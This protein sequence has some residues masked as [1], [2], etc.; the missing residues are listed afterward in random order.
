MATMLNE[1]GYNVHQQY[2]AMLFHYHYIVPR[3]GAR[4]GY[5]GKPKFESPLGPDGCPIEY[6]FKW[7]TATSDPDVR[8]C[9][10]CFGDYTGSMADPFNTKETKD[11]IYELS[12]KFPSIDLTW[13]HMLSSLVYDSHLPSYTNNGGTPT[14]TM[15][16]GF[17]LLK[18]GIMVKAYFIVPRSLHQH[19]SVY[20]GTFWYKAVKALAPSSA[21]AEKLFNFLAYDPFG[22]K[23][24]PAVLAIDCVHPSKS[25]IKFYHQTPDTSFAAVRAI[26][27]MGGAI[28]GLDDQLNEL[29]D[30]IKAITRLPSDFPE[31]EQ[32]PTASVHYDDGLHQFDNVPEVMG[33]YICYFD[34]KPGSSKPD[35]KIYVPTRV[36]G[37]SDAQVTK[38]LTSWMAARGRTRYI[39]NYDRIL[40]NICTHRGLDE[41]NGMHT[42]V[43]CTFSKGELAITSYLEPEPYHPKRFRK[44]R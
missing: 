17:D 2:E 8:T 18:T 37:Q 41:G 39:Q 23:L 7:D 9:I 14:T 22:K 12:L 13:F 43:S 6:S 27:T 19:L 44:L 1:A 25:R 36:Y 5:D 34:I 32:T 38:G 10:T 30:L 33:G 29:Y 3:M 20:N 31:T 26:M 21:A 42:F 15:L 24:N 11:F 28:E 35:I 16:A 40:K 4:P